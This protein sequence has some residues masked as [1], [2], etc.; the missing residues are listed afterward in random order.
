MITRHTRRT[1]FSF[2][3]IILVGVGTMFVGCQ[4]DKVRSESELN[5]E[6]RKVF[7]ENRYAVRLKEPIVLKNHAG[8]VVGRLEPGCILQSPSIDDCEDVDLSDND[9]MKVLFDVAD[10]PQWE[11]VEGLPVLNGSPVS[12]PAP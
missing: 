8:E 4:K 5:M 2:A 9:R 12:H 1:P 11:K 7:F 6:F 10:R 3:A